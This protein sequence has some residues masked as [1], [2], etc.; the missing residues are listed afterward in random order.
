ME[1][2]IPSQSFERLFLWGILLLLLSCVQGD[3]EEEKYGVIYASDCEG[4]K[5]TGQTFIGY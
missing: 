2:M 1:G 3:I 4:E 5:S